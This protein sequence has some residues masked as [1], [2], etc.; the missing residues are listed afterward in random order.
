VTSSLGPWLTLPWTFTLSLALKWAFTLRLALTLAFT[1]GLTLT[2]SSVE[3]ETGTALIDVDACFFVE[4]A[5]ALNDQGWVVGAA[6]CS[7]MKMVGLD[8]AGEGEK[9]EGWRDE[10]T[11]IKMRQADSFQQSGFGH[12]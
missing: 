1:L 10:D 11:I 2:W 9:Q 3:T 4:E 7:H 8:E 6:S 12:K 5:E